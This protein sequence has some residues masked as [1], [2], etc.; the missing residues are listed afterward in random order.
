MPIL[1]IE[2]IGRGAVPINGQWQFHLGDDPHWAAPAYD[3][4]KW[5]HITADKTWGAQTHPSY[6]GYAWYRRHLDIPPSSLP[7]PKFAILMPPIEDA[8]EFFWNG[9]PIGHQGKP[10]PH[11]VWYLEG[12]Q[13]FSLPVPAKGM[14]DGVLAIRVWT[15]KLVSYSPDT[16]GGLTAPPV[17][18]SPVSI[19]QFVGAEDFAAI[20]RSFYRR[21]INI[22]FAIIG[23]VALVTWTQNRTNWL[24]L[25]FGL[26]SLARGTTFLTR[27]PSISQLLPYPVLHCALQ[28]GYS[29]VDCTLMLILLYLF[30]LQE[31]S[32]IRR[33][34]TIA[35]AFNLSASILDGVLAL[36]WATPAS[37]LSG[38]TLFSQ[39]SR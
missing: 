31:N 26:W 13:S 16:I 11:A 14:T 37:P 4:S 36:F 12:R 35:I 20:H 17:L 38:P 3:D 19:A 7:N 8:Y 34:T 9:V 24:F 2:D 22:F 28:I 15:A 33:W 30:Q 29:I 18:G 23:L 21:I 1:A 25:W 32:R 27:L 10:P 6:T 39:P 5:E